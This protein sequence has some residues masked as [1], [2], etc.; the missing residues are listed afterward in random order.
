MPADADS[1]APAADPLTDSPDAGDRVA[2]ALREYQALLDSGRRPDRGSFLSRFGDVAGTLAEAMD[3]LD[4]LYGAVGPPPASD[5]LAAPDGRPAPAQLGDF[6]IV[7]EVGRGG[8][9]VVYEAE[10]LSLGRRV[11]LK[12]LPQ[13]AALDERQRHRFKT[14][15]Q[16]AAHLHHTNI[17]PVFAVGSDRGVHYYAMQ[18]ID[19]R[20]LADVVR[21]LRQAARPVAGSAPTAADGPAAPTVGEDDPTHRPPSGPSSGLPRQGRDHFKALARLGVQA[22]DALE[23]AHSMGVVHRDVKPANLLVDGRGNLWVTDFGLAHVHGNDVTATGDVLGT[24]RYMSPEQAEG[25]RGL[26]DHRTDIYSLG[27]SLYELF[28]L[29]EAFPSR[30][31]AALLRQILHDDPAPPRRHCRGLPVELETIILKAMAKRPADRYATAGE[32]ADD[33]RRFLADQPIL[34][35]RPTVWQIMNKWT[36]RHS[37]AVSTAAAAVV[38]LAVVLAF[39]VFRLTVAYQ[40][41]SDQQAKLQD[42]QDLTEKAREAAVHN[43]ARAE[44]TSKQTLDVLQK[45]ALDLAGKR[46]AKDPAWG[47]QSEALLDAALNTCGVLARS[48]NPDQIVRMQAIDAGL[49]VARAYAAL[50]QVDKAKTAAKQAIEW[51]RRLVQDA[52]GQWTCRFHQARGHRE[53][54]VL[55]RELGETQAAADQFKQALDAWNYPEPTGP[56]PYEAS[57]TIDN[58]G[59]LRAEAGDKA[60]ADHYYRQAYQ[61]RLRLLKMAE[62]EHSKD[63]RD[64]ALSKLVGDHTRLGQMQAEAGDRAG[65]EEHFKAALETAVTLAGER[66]GAD[67]CMLAQG[68]CL[69]TLGDL[70]EGR[71]PAAAKGYYQQAL[72]VLSGLTAKSPGLSKARRLL[73][74]VHVA[75]GAVVPAG[76]ADHFRAARDLL[77]ALVADSPDGGPGLP[78]ENENDLAWFLATCPDPQFRDPAR[79]VELARRAVNRGPQ[80]ANFLNTLGAACCRAGDAE[81]A[82]AALEKAVDL[83]K[84]GEPLDWLFLAAARAK[85]GRADAAR[86][87]LAKA[88]SCPGLRTPEFVRLRAELDGATGKPA[89][90][91]AR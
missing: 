42:Q 30:D 15:A 64:I 88:E 25:R 11:A 26:V 37:A 50:G 89:S 8:M 35:K 49:Q 63:L 53:F 67:D 72:D 6:R 17:V 74:D 80:Q 36:R 73:A 56:C 4:F 27:V 76:A 40:K 45:V 23:Y 32:L 10:Q 91:A 85:L 41:L 38:V 86:E 75:L 34:A 87:A 13:A 90:P 65:A 2:A 21:G 82:V 19:G 71:D 70:A 22:A 81:Q 47:Q 18:F 59:D 20:T 60:G 7:R 79:A 28:A 61:Q 51:N 43:A 55:L 78:G 54:G 16:A 1:L 31:R 84:G 29:R 62:A 58:L 83:H 69:R 12:V 46:L 57:E 44:Q 14:E 24:L 66:H 68:Q 77:T 5:P 48:D 3:G 9:G 33:L 39:A 52:P